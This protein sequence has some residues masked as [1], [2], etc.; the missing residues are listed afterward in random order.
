[1]KKLLLLG[2]S[3]QQI[4]ALEYANKIGLFTVLCD[5]LPDNPGQEFADR[6]YCASTTDKEEIL[7]IA[8]IEKVDGIVS[9]A[10]DPGAPTAAY[11]AEKLGLPT[12]SYRSVEIMSL[13]DKF[14]TF[15][16]E[17]GF[18]CPHAE[19]FH[20]IEDAKS[21]LHHFN[22]PIMIKPNDSSGSKG[23]NRANEIEE[24]EKYIEIAFENSRQKIIILEEFITQDHPHMIA[25]DCFVVDGEVVY[26]GFLNSHRDFEGNPFVPVGT[27]YPI[28]LSD[29]RLKQVQSEMQRVFELL[30]VKFGAFNIEVM[31]DEKDDLYIIEVGPRNGGNMIPDLLY[32]A[33]GTDLIAATI[34]N[35]MGL[36][37][38]FSNSLKDT[39]YL[40]TR[41][42][43][44]Y[45]KG[46]LK[47]IVFD[48]EIQSKVFK[49]VLYKSNGDSIDSFNGSN[50]AVGI[51]FLKF[52]TENEMHEILDNAEKHIQINIE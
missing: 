19:S 13:K 17:N 8:E 22:F 1:M 45:Q 35:A 37:H 26:W 32:M 16:K 51:I 47:S 36:K 11:V 48:Q 10:S 2:G 49:K 14:R 29:S 21:S 28:C 3:T 39:P 52:E 41:I 9:Y 30:D 43:H 4:P 50:K 42:L 34:D 12:N 40:A 33:T 23:V 6:Y 5:F 27:S 38:T 25:G 24:C 31:I 7:R 44:T 18:N 15:L 46:I 20:N